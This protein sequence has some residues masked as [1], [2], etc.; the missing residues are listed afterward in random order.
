MP[1]LHLI[2]G[3]GYIFRAYHALPPLT[4]SKGVPT[5][6]VRGFAA[7]LL[8]DLRQLKPT[9]VAVC[10]D[11]DS[12]GKRAEIYPEYKAHRPPPPEDLVPQFAL[13]RDVVRALNVPMLELAGYEADDLIATL[14]KRAMADGF[15]VVVHSGDKD[16]MQLVKD[17]HC[18]FYDGL[19]DKWFEDAAVQE[20]WGVP[21]SQ[22][23]DLLALIG[24][25]VDNVPGIPGVG[26]KTAAMLL[27]QFGSLD[28]VLERAEE[29]A[30][31]KLRESV[32][33]H[34][35]Q[36]RLAKQLVTLDEAA[37]LDVPLEALARKPVD[38]DTARSLFTEL[39]MFSLL[40]DLPKSESAHV[41]APASHAEAEE[42][43]VVEAPPA[44][45]RPVRTEVVIV[46]TLHDLE[47]LAHRLTRATRVALRLALAGD[48]PLR[49]P[50]VGI[51]FATDD[52]LAFVPVGLGRLGR[53]ALSEE[54]VLQALAPVLESAHPL[55]D[56]HAL[57]AAMTALLR[58]GVRLGGV[59]VDVEGCSHLLNAARRTHALEDLARE[60][61][62]CELPGPPVDA[63]KKPSFAQASPEEVAPWAASGADAVRLLVPELLQEL[64][65]GG[66][67]SLWEEVERPVLP[68]LAAMEV[69]GI[70]VDADAL[71]AQSSEFEG[72][73]A[74]QLAEIEKLAGHAFNVNSPPQ[75]AQVLF[76][77][78]QLPV[79][80]RGKTGPS[81]DAEVL[82]KL[83]EQHPLPEKILEYRTIS[84]LK[85]TYLDALPQEVADDGR[86]HTTFNPIG[87]ATGRLSSNDPNLQNI[88]IRTDLGRRIRAAFTAADGCRLVSADY[89]QV[90]LRILAHV[91]GDE[92]LCE[93][94]RVGEDVHTRTAAETYGVSPADVTSEMRRVAKM[95]NYAIAY[96]L[97]PYGLSSRIGIARDEAK[98]TIDAY[99]A[100]YT[101]VKR[102]LD[103]TIRV[104]REKGY[105]ETLLGR[106][107]PLADLRSKNAAARQ[108]AERVAVNAP[109][110][111][112]AAD[113]VK[114][115]MV[116]V[117]R[118][119]G[120]M[121]RV[122][123]LLQVHDELLFE[124]PEAEVDALEALVK[125]IMERAV[126][127]RVPL[128]VDVGHGRTWD[129][130][131]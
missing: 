56:G 54:R 75:L 7:M 83:A 19:K 126:A 2:D 102:W 51:G 42:Q 112:S 48:R 90:E 93:S 73:L 60:R 23:G 72:E 128:V 49:D 124:V 46:D 113:I 82:E 131:H 6:A 71:R 24:D 3:S 89:S 110:Q 103:E 85:N 79:I 95:I 106:R 98:R 119:L 122:R 78:L 37:P 117:D 65:A 127:L 9:H 101:G 38:A 44:E 62:L 97:S 76:E 36:V 50:I 100:R 22:V 30:R 59:G 14:A 25:K 18:R 94:F 115:A 55:K 111:G 5:G 130:A 57:K 74:R 104:G 105:V 41:V 32:L 12:R 63:K 58:R 17:G 107:R 53:A 29:I 64:A 61:L 77:E 11:L 16:L 28:A 33:A 13:V 35:D 47:A 8:K 80:R 114:R 20:K 99:F 86:I 52:E 91:S 40:R 121:P 81:T 123:M 88:P 87:A 27:A 120:A 125:P 116:D 118:A 68:I 66:V 21:P 39:E 129:D 69:A 10:M 43:A 26:E 4:T 45:P 1:V 70:R 84:K 108:A 67:T 92:A 34:R 96:G 31:P 109:I 15:E